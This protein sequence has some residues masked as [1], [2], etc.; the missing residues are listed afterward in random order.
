MEW[1][2]IAQDF[3]PDGGLRDIYI[4]N[5]SLLVWENV[6]ELLTADPDLLEFW[7]DGDRTDPPSDLHKIF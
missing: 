6:W 5:A 4:L 3:E 2:S 1:S 7:V